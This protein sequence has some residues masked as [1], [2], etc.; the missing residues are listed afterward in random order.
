[1][2]KINV[3]WIL[4]HWQSFTDRVVLGIIDPQTVS[5]RLVLS[6]TCL[7]FLLACLVLLAGHMVGDDILSQA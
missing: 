5:D 4:T 6:F 3:E 7:D 1:M 2:Y